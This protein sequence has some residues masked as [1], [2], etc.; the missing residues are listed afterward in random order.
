M[1]FTSTAYAPFC[2]SIGMTLPE[3]AFINAI[4]WAVVVLGELPTGM[5]ADGRSRAWSL[6][7]GA[8]LAAVSHV[9][10]AFVHGFW[11]ALACESIMGIGL[12]FM[13]GADQAWIADALARRGESGDL[14]KVLATSV[15]GSGICCLGGGVI[16]AFIGAE[17]LRLT[18]LSSGIAC[19]LSFAIAM[20][21]MN[22]DGEPT[23]RV[24]EIEALRLSVGALRR[25]SGLVW[26]MAAAC[27]V[28]L[29]LPFNHYWAPFFGGMTGQSGLSFIWV[30]IYG[31]C[32]LGGALIRRG[33][34]RDGNEASGV[35]AA[36]VL[37][38]VGMAG[39]GMAA[40]LA[41]P[42]LLALVH[43]IGRGAFRPL[44]DTFVQRRIDSA[45]RATY[46]SL[47]SFVSKLGYAF[48]LFCVWIF[49]RGSE[50]DPRLI[51]TTWCVS[52]ILMVVIAAAL[53]V[54]RPKRS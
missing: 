4:F 43:E 20:F 22:G 32:V 23:E 45:F 18:M 9:A 42:L 26:A 6:R 47:Q 2:L 49:S 50:A 29:N 15:V 34:W 16:G 40:G 39:A 53:W 7:I 37:M 46:G 41:A 31:G 36:I 5:L 10:Y 35:V 8:A 11:G 48:I 19:L 54:F 30:V 38:G 44:I 17:S 21:F 28:G 1:G 33:A 3:I 13:S 14:R 24:N 27:A 12:A 52:G 51:T 25:E